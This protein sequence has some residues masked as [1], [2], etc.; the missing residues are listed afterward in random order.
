M[1]AEGNQK[2]TVF[3]HA[4]TQRQHA[5][6]YAQ[7]SCQQRRVFVVANASFLNHKASAFTSDH[8]QQA[9]FSHLNLLNKTPSNSSLALNTKALKNSVWLKLFVVHLSVKVSRQIG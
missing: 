5:S 3:Y 6:N 1:I 8:D 4:E 7:I 2:H 9:N